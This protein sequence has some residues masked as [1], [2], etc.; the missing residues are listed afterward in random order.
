MS[1][2]NYSGK[3][4]LDVMTNALNYNTY[5]SN[6]IYSEIRKNDFIVDF[7][8]GNGIF[9]KS[10]AK[11][12]FNISCIETDLILITQ[13]C[14]L[15][16]TVRDCIESFEDESI[17]Y[18][19]SINVLEHIENDSEI[20][21]QMYAKLRAD[22][23]ILIFVPAFQTLYTSMDKKVGHFR[24]YNLIKLKN[25][26]KKEG[27]CIDEAFYVDSIGVIATLIYK[28]TDSGAGNINL[29]LLKIY[30]G[31]VF[32]MSRILDKILHRFLGKNIV[33]IASKKIN[34]L[35]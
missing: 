19:Y 13:L 27:F 32:P 12:G 28:L 21:Q 17:D 11:S 35:Y 8:A 14:S 16:L 4:N 34:R 25:L 33:I 31:W 7:G 3:D 6:L 10:I 26:I 30:D 5:I 22:G 20:I 24:R 1:T 29:G 23:R 2:N 18:I 15:G 9:A